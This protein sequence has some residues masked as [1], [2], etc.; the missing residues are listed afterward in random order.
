MKIKVKD[1]E[2]KIE[3]LAVDEKPFLYEENGSLTADNLSA[4]ID[5]RKPATFKYLKQFSPVFHIRPLAW[6]IDQP[7]TLGFRSRF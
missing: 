7:L 5:L 6:S 3:T 2:I 1:S 4:S